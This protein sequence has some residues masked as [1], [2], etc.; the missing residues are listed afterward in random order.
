MASSARMTSLFRQSYGG[1]PAENFKSPQDVL[2]TV[3]NHLGIDPRKT[4]EDFG[5]RPHPILPSGKVI[6]ELF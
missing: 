4:Y 3:Y 1:E 5:G 2:A 6:E